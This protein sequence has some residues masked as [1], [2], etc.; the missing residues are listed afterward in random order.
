MTR[1]FSGSSIHASAADRSS[2]LHGGG[3]GGRSGVYSPVIEIDDDSHSRFVGDGTTTATSR[4]RPI[5]ETTVGGEEWQ[6]EM[7]CQPRDSLLALTADF[8]SQCSAR[9]Q[10]LNKKQ[11]EKPVELLDHKCLTRFISHT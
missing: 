11:Q 3:G 4:Q 9:L 10:E 2:R 7:Y 5:E 6:R 8:V 1:H